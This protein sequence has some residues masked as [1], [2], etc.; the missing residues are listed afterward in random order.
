MQKNKGRRDIINLAQL[1]D[2]AKQLISP[3]SRLSTSGTLKQSSNFCLDSTELSTGPRSSGEVTRQ[4]ASARSNQRLVNSFL[5]L[6]LFLTERQSYVHIC[7]VNVELRRL[8]GFI[9]Q[10][11]AIEGEQGRPPC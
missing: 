2:V 3:P 5:C 7:G 1:N 10:R 9:A 11:P 8:R 6:N 4:R